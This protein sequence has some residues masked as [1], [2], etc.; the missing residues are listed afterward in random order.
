MKKT[1]KFKFAVAFSCMTAIVLFMF[2]ASMYT[3]LILIDNIEDYSSSLA[4]LNEFRYN[5]NEFNTN[6]ENYLET[7]SSDSLER[8]Q[9]LST[10]LNELCT[11]ISKKYQNSNDTMQ[12]S[13]VTAISS[14]YGTYLNQIQDLINMDDK[15][16]ALEAYSTKYSKTSEYISGYIEKMISYNYKASG[17]SLENANAK[18]E[19]FK[20]INIFTFV[21]L[22]VLIVILFRMVF[23]GVVTPI[24]KLARQAQQ[25]ANYN[26]DVEDIEVKSKDEVSDLVKMFNHMREKL[27]LMFDSNIKNLQMAEELLVQIQGNS[28]LEEF[29]QYQKNIG[30]EMFKEANMDHLT[31]IMNQNAFVH[32]VNENIKSISRDELCAMFVVDLDNFTS[33]N[34]TLGDGSDEVLK[35][36]ASELNKIFKDCGFIARWNRDVFVGFVSG[37]PDEEF[38]YKKC[39]EI[40]SSL[41]IHFRYKKKYHPVTASIGVCLC[42]NPISAEIMFENAE[43]EVRNVKLSGKNGYH[44]AVF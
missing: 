10:E 22:A 28:N 3:Y 43:G 34:T 27:K 39:K 44:V 31:N 2:T 25:I 7:D 37:L 12:Q 21:L 26:F 42:V 41:S 17:E 30:E 20:A 23:S 38:V 32:C 5:F 13:L 40:S 9:E 8:C 15:E 1:L 24:Q 35:Y 29:V 36:T 33:I 18:I 16:S 14:S 19:V 4:E 11:S 6:V